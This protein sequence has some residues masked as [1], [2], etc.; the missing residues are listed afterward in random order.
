MPM[1]MRADDNDDDANDGIFDDILS[2]ILGASSRVAISLDLDLVFGAVDVNVDLACTS[3]LYPL[4][5]L[6]L[7]SP[8]LLLL[9]LLGSPSEIQE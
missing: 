5:P 9:L 8:L 4:S 6:H 2:E 7:P 1:S 3:L